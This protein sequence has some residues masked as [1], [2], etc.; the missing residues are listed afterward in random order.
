MISV[1]THIAASQEK[2]VRLQEYGV[3]IFYSCPTKSALKK[4]LSKKLIKVNGQIASTATFISGGEEIVLLDHEMPALKRKLELTLNVLYEDEHMAAIY[5]PAGIQV[6]GN[7][8]KTI[9]NALSRNLKMSMQVDACRPQPVHRLDY[10]TTGVL[11][12]G[13]TASSIRLLNGM[14]EEKKVQKTYLA[15]AMGV[16]KVTNGEMNMPIDQKEASTVY[17]VLETVESKRFKALN[18]V[19]L[20]PQSGRRHQIRKHLSGMQ[21]AILGDADYSP[22]KSL[23]KGKGLYLHAYSVELE[24]PFTH[25]KLTIT[26]EV[27]EKI[28]KLFSVLATSSLPLPRP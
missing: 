17:E 20:Y 23:L 18:L 6:S 24:H 25:D 11:L 15:V 12:V 26:A 10:P 27:P 5:K 2:P 13:K 4:K 16:M 19:K 14:F 1:E 8:F 7:K 3:G 21:N 28:L 22:E 9:A